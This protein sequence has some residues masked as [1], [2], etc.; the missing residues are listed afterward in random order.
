M[1]W[2]LPRLIRLSTLTR[3]ESRH[4]LKHGFYANAEQAINKDVRIFARASWNDGRNEIL[5]FT[6][7]DRSVSGGVSAKGT[8]WGR[9]NDTFGL[10]EQLMACRVRIGIFSRPVVLAS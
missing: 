6:D 10:G 8:S 5:S 7:I 1:R 9:S 4:N 3:L 2:R